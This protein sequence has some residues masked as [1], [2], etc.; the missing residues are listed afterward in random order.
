MKKNFY[1]IVFL[2]MGVLSFQSMAYAEDVTLEVMSAN[3]DLEAAM[4]VSLD[5][6]TTGN[7]I[8]TAYLKSTFDV[9]LVSYKPYFYSPE[10]L[11]VK[12]F[13]IMKDANMQNSNFRVRSC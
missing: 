2:I 9:Q 1:A 10:P 7:D 4:D 12:A 5:S 6:P 13:K 8:N 3:I 11:K